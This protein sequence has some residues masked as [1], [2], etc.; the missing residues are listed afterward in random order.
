ML[1]WKMDALFTL[2]LLNYIKI[3]NFTLTI[4]QLSQL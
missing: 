3:H 4:T 2:V 1:I